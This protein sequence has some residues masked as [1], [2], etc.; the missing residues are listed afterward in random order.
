MEDATTSKL[1]HDCLEMDQT[2]YPDV[3]EGI[4]TIALLKAMEESLASGRPVA[5]DAIL[6]TY[7]L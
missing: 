6:K 3:R 2:A 4:G 5:V 7:G 1:I